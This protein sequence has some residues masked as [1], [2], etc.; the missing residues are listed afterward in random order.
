MRKTKK[1]SLA[2][3][4]LKKACQA[5]FENAR[6]TDTAPIRAAGWRTVREIAAAD[7]G[8]S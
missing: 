5:V 8:L 3:A 6:I 2:P 7:L 4:D 1:P